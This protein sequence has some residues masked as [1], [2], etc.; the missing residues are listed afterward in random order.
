MKNKKRNFLPLL[1][2][3]GLVGLIILVA[4][5]SW[6]ILKQV[7][8]KKE[9]QKE[10]LKLEEEA[11][12]ISQENIL[13]QERISYF[14][15]SEYKEREAKEKLNLKSPEEEVVIVKPGVIKK[16]EENEI[17]P[18]NPVLKNHNL[19]SNFIKWWRYFTHQ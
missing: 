3:L 9:I 11:S 18:V 2:R 7:S 12:R 19:E 14:E 13:A 1:I 6:S 4:L 17:E 10:I 15:S 8:K 16:E 5:I